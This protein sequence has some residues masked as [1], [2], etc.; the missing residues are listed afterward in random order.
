[1]KAQIN[2][3]LAAITRPISSLKEDPKN[4]R[5]HGKRDLALLVDSLKAYGQQKPIVGLK[6]GT[7]IAG[8]GTLR[9]A[10]EL[11]WDSIAVVQFDSA[12]EAK[13]RAFAIIDNRTAEL[14]S[15]DFEALAASLTELKDIDV[16]FS[17]T[18]L[19]R[20]LGNLERI[21]VEAHSRELHIGDGNTTCPKCGFEFDV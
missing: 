13:A 10:K 12:D 14:S 18:E 20:M 7:I 8:N 11:G 16:G 2:K 21:S 15:W 5:K 6:D 17:A 19:D 1:M 4:A 3:D 9:A